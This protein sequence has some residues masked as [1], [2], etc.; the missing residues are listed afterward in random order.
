MSIED[1]SV[2]VVLGVGASR[3]VGA[4][5]ARRFA[6][7]GFHVVLAGRTEG[8]LDAIR[9]EIRDAGVTAE[10]FV[11]D[12]TNAGDVERLMAHADSLG[13]GLRVAVY[14]VG[15]NRR[16]TLDDLDMAVFEKAWREN[17]FGGA[18]FAKA[19][20]W[21]MRARG[22][23]TMIFTG[24]TASLRARPPFLPFASAKA[25]L[26]A[27]AQAAARELGPDG[28]HVSHVVVDGGIAGDKLF[29]AFPDRAKRAGE[30]GLLDPDAIAD[31]YWALHVQHRSAW[32]FELDLRPYGESW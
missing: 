22:Q 28:I 27:V 2:A 8:G 32:T 30:D 29:R 23:G 24:A 9:D 7:E 3:G 20:A 6:G 14:N 19:A 15:N 16:G 18:L 11:T 4:A 1:K 12:A 21:H 13:G 10:S 31:A 26:R 25:A 17:A 5:V